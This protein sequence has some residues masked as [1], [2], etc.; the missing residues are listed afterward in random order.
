MTGRP[1]SKKFGKSKKANATG[2]AYR[3]RIIMITAMGNVPNIRRAFHHRCDDYMAK[4]I[5][6]KIS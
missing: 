6:K 5:N 2:K 3:I 4:P 1:C